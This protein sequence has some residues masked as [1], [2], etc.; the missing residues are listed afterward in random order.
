MA[1]SGVDISDSLIMPREQVRASSWMPPGGARLAWEDMKLD[2]CIAEL[3]EPEKVGK[4]KAILR[5]VGIG[6]SS[7]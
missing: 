6:K 7:D 1:N 5:C 4:I 3:P 2:V